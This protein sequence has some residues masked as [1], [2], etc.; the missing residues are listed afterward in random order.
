MSRI[1]VIR[2]IVVMACASVV[3]G[4]IGIAP[5][6]ASTE[7]QSA[8]AASCSYRDSTYLGAAPSNAIA[9]LYYCGTYYTVSGT[10][11]DDSCDN[12]T[13]YLD[14]YGS[15]GQTQR[16]SVS[17]CGNSNGYAFTFSTSL[18]YVDLRARACNGGGCSS[19][20]WDTLYT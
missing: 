14:I 5:A 11:W 12:R 7:T 18:S 2:A 19:S 13:A 16:A 3:I 4:L 17:G 1:R 10:I 6:S 8:A 9:Y 15:N 20:Y